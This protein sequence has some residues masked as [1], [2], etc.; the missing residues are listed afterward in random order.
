MKKNNYQRQKG[1][2]ILIGLVFFAVLILFSAAILRY[3][4]TYLKSESQ[5]IAKVQALQLAEAGIDKAAY[6]LNQNSSYTGE[7]NTVLGNGNFTITVSSIDSTHK[8][9][10]SVGT[11]AFSG[12]HTATRTAKA[13]LVINNTVISFRYGIQAGNGGFSLDNSSTITGN[14]FSTGSVIGLNKNYIYGDIVSAGPGGWVYGIHATGNVF[15]HTIGKSGKSNETSID[16][17]AYY[18]AIT[19]TTVTGTSH[20]G[21]PDQSPVALP[22]SDAQIQ[23]WENDAAAGNTISTCDGNGNYEISGNTSLGPKKI[24]CNLVIKNVTLTVTGPLWVTGNI[25]IQTNATVRMDS[26]LGSQNVAF[27]ADKITDRADSGKISIAQQSNFYGS[28]SPGSFVFLISQNNSAET[29]GGT[30]AITQNQGTAALVSYAS[31]GLITMQQS[32]NV[33]EATGY[34]IALSNSANV[35]YDLGLPSTLFESGPGASW[36][37]APGSYVIQ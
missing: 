25:E 33:K 11:V 24:A 31:H 10:T 12:G 29:G 16:K 18:V 7:S 15:A 34:K 32:A 8:R 30:V 3:V 5:N 14:A 19:N 36:T 26:S 4:S 17:D 21:S 23:L 28:G 35:T 22:I 6:E 9:V 20:P 37:F 1:Q 2:I 27:I 13:T